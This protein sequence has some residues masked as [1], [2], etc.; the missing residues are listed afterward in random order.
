MVRENAERTLYANHIEERG[1]DL[2]ALVCEHD[3]EGIVAKRTV[4][5]LCCL[6]LVLLFFASV[7]LLR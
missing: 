3:L 6:A 2:F 4:W 1:E 7:L 5:E